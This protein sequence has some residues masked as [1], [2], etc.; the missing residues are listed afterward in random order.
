MSVI[1]QQESPHQVERGDE[2]TPVV[3]KPA[4]IRFSYLL[5]ILATKLQT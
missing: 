1:L 4:A 2:D 3:A 5:A